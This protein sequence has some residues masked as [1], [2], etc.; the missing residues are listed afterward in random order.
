MFKLFKTKEEKQEDKQKSLEK[1]LQ[2]FTDK[3]KKY[4]NC[5]AFTGKDV[6]IYREP[7]IVENE[8]VISVIRVDTPKGYVNYGLI[9]LLNL[10]YGEDFLK[11]HRHNFIKLKDQ[12]EK[13]GLLL[14]MNCKE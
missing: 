5:Y 9:W 12:M 6:V 13:L 4:F 3:Y 1:E 8:L 7:K 2:E 14:T 11:Q 10:Q